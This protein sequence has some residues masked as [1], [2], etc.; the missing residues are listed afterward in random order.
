MFSDMLDA[1]EQKRPPVETFYD[2]YVVNAI[3]DACYRSIETRRW[4]RVALE[5]WRGAAQAEAT[6]ELQ[7]YDEQFWLIKR[8]RMPDG[9]TKV[10]LKHRHTGEVSQRIE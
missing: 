7:P 1:F 6:L 5:V 3:V 9:G 10:I 4:E 8:E 2:G